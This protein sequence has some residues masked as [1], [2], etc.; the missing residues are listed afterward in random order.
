MTAVN[1]HLGRAISGV[2]S[3][4]G[5]QATLY[6]A[7]GGKH[8]RT[9]LVSSG[10]D[11]EG[12]ST[13]AAGIAIA[14]ARQSGGQVL[15]IDANLRNPM[16]A[17]WFGITKGPGLREYLESGTKPVPVHATSEPGLSVM[18][19]GEVGSI[20]PHLHHLHARLKGFEKDYAYV[21]ID[22]DSTLHAPE[23]TLFAPHID[24]VILVAECEKTK[25]EIITQ[26]AEKWTGLGANVLGVILNKRQ[27][28]IP[29][30]F[31]A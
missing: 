9:L 10:R 1:P 4:N 28:Y 15:L 29:G 2:R 23:I 17:E 24:G 26:S 16:L 25:R 13:M 14:L 22:G 3:F 19:A 7:A 11:R 27:Y 20:A 5:I 12:K 21:V 31:Y 6:T 30:V 8:I 18:T